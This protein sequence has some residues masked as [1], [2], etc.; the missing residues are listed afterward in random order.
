ME[1]GAVLSILKRSSPRIL[2]SNFGLKEFHT[3][4]KLCQK[5]DDK[6]KKNETT[7]HDENKKENEVEKSPEKAPEEN[8]SSS[9][10]G[11]EQND[12]G[13][14]DKDGKSDADKMISLFTKAVLWL[15][16]IYS[17]GIVLS[18][19]VSAGRGRPESPLNRT[20]SWNEF[21]YHMLAKG[22][23]KEI[24][25][26]PDMELVTIILHDGAIVKGKRAE[27]HYYHMSVADTIKFE[28]K[29]RDVEQRLGIRESECFD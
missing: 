27:S 2:N 5:D 23:V 4:I 9:G 26:R 22:E 13:K 18:L 21:V 16:I 25:V 3:N 28:Q 1:L 12:K 15:G 14:E 19:A 17:F 29:L 11:H 7:N 20:I 24:I 6:S 8:S 10:D